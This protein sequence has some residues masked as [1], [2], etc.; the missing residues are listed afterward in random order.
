MEIVVRDAVA[1]TPAAGCRILRLLADHRSMAL[2]AT[3][4]TGPG[5]PL[6]LLAREEKLEVAE[7][8]R[9]MLR[10][11]DVRAALERRGYSPAVRGEVHL[12]VRDA[13]FPENARRWTVEAAGGRGN[14]REGGSGAIAIDVRGLAA[15]YSG[16][17]PAEDLRSAGLCEGSDADL[18]HATAL[19]AGPAPWLADYY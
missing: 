11:V 12:R 18:A 5:D 15:L 17:L 2:A 14:V 13:V 1:R 19:F 6:L 9:W 4:T 16:Y 3:I 10:L 8:F 7:H